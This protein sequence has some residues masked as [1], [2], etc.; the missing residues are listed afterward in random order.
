MSQLYKGKFE[1]SFANKINMI[2]WNTEPKSNRSIISV[3]TTSRIQAI[4]KDNIDRNFPKLSEVLES[5]FERT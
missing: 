5:E 4:V 2:D 1:I 3:P